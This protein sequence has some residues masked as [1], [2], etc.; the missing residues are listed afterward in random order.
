MDFLLSSLWK[1][2]SED[3]LKDAKGE[4]QNYVTARERN[5]N[6]THTTEKYLS[7]T[8]GVSQAQ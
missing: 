7:L 4:R 6:L 5:K 2:T 8:C 1:F 3:F